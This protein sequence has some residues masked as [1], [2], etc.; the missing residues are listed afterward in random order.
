M[1]LK[2]LAAAVAGVIL[3]AVVSYQVGYRSA[4]DE[5][6]QALVREQNA[7]AQARLEK[8]ITRQQQNDARAAAA[9]QEGAVKTQTITRE[10]VKYIR[11]PGRTVCKFDA[12]RVELKAAAVENANSIKGYDH[13]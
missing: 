6:R 5:G 9:E 8:Q 12:E 11:T 3:A 7:K 1:N 2:V 13:E 10:V 4:W